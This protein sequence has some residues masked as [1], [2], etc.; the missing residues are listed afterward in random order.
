MLYLFL[1]LFASQLF[2][3]TSSVIGKEEFENGEKIL[4][5]KVNRNS[6]P[7]DPNT[8]KIRGVRGDLP[9]EVESREETTSCKENATVSERTDPE[10]L[11]TPRLHGEIP[12]EKGE[13]KVDNCRRVSLYVDFIDLGLSD[14]INAP[15]GYN[16]YQCKGKCSTTQKFLNRALLLD[17]MEK[18][19]GIKTEGE[20][21]CVPTKL[22][23]LSILTVDERENV[24]LR[25]FED[26]VVEEC[27]CASKDSKSNDS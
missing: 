14:T 16:A 20:A 6:G 9:P 10:V 23:P 26:M 8:L 22:Q 21:C 5:S 4:S 25:T 11:K 15:S 2:V 1:S 13:H 12:S 3:A 24:V 7:T 19:K 17:L 27:G 18:K